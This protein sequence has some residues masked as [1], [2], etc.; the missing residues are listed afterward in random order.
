MLKFLCLLMAFT[1]LFPL[2]QDARAQM[3][4]P[5]L[6]YAAVSGL[7]RPSSTAPGSRA[8]LIVTITVKPGFHINSDS[9]NDPDL[10]PTVVTATAAKG[11]VVSPA[12]Y[13]HATVINAPSLSQKPLSVYVGKV[14]VKV[15][16]KISP[17]VKPG[18]YKVNVSVSYQGCNSNS[19]YP[20][21]TKTLT[22]ILSVS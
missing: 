12:A 22:A 9:P 13:P 18:L 16:L 7:V 5:V 17:I 10:I 4:M 19:C 8:S 14:F 1:G 20:P 3:T 2:A 11:I 6:N 21:D 15:P